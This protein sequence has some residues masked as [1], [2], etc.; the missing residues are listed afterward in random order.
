[1]K[2]WEEKWEG[3]NKRKSDSHFD[4]KKKHSDR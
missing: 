2:N 4:R 3:N 1:M